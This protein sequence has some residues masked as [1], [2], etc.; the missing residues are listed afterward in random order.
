[1]NAYATTSVPAWAVTGTTEDVGLDRAAR[2]WLL[3]GIGAAGRDRVAAWR[4]TADRPARTVEA[5]DAASARAVLVEELAAARVGVRV[6]VAGPV[7]ECLL[8]RA[9]LLG[10]G[11][12]DEEIRTCPTGHGV[13]DVY[14]A[15][16]R[17]A[18]RAVATI[19]EVTP[20][21]WCG[22]PLHVY[23]HV[24]RTSGRFLGFHANAERLPEEV[25]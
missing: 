12:V 6:A 10:A 19:G 9:Q 20:C 5:D 11:L 24:N 25:S 18:A 23:H 16:C 1:M 13:I 15:H 8:V 7:G 21:H 3:V 17:R 4:A 22:A 14:C 2:I